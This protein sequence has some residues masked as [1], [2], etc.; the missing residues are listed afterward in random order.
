MI[1]LQ[2]LSQIFV[3][4]WK[5]KVRLVINLLRLRNAQLKKDSWGDGVWTLGT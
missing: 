2:H 4:V 5:M 3:Y 1:T